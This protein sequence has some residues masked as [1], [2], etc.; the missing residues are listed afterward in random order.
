M[1]VAVIYIKRQF[2][3]ILFFIALLGSRDAAELRTIA[4]YYCGPCSIPESSVACGLCLLLVLV[5]VR[6]VCLRVLRLSSLH[7]N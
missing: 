2:V 3:V 4:F 5:F 1:W 7:K 6:R